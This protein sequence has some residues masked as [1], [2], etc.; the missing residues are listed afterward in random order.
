MNYPDIKS[1][2]ARQNWFPVPGPGKLL[3]LLSMLLVSVVPAGSFAGETGDA[4]A[5]PENPANM[6]VRELH[7]KLIYIM[8]N[9]DTLHYQGRYEAMQGIV[10]T[11]FDT[12]LIVKVILSRYWRALD[13]QQKTDFID[14]FRR[15]SVATYAS[16]FDGYAGESFVDL[17]TEPLKKGRLLIKTE[18][19]RPGKKPVQLDYLMHENDGQ[20][21]IIS[22]IANGV[23]D[24]SLKRAEY[25][26][27]IKDK[28]FAGLVDDV[29]SKIADMEKEHVD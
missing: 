21:M 27:V 14:L 20:W 24:L 15:L 4:A 3:L 12:A 11:R 18:L 17:S 8:Q 10:A 26:T 5:L 16:R 28:G 29:T 22:V 23:N 1:A 2:V 6:V 13:E 19:Q 9:A 25:A 7:E